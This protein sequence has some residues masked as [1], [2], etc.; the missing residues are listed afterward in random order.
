MSDEP[1]IERAEALL[2]HEMRM[3]GYGLR[4]ERWDRKGR[5]KWRL[6]HHHWQ[7]RRLV[8]GLEAL[9]S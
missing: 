4:R 8:R 3:R 9:W 6:E 5:W 1:D 7:D 2:R